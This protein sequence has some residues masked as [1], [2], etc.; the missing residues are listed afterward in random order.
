[1]EERP[2]TEKVGTGPDVKVG[3]HFAQAVGYA[4]LQVKLTPVTEGGRLKSKMKVEATRFVLTTRKKAVAGKPKGTVMESGTMAA[5]RP[6]EYA[7][8]AKALKHM[9]KT[10]TAGLR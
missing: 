2:A 8:D 7:W 9:P 6:F 3:R 10:S 4:L 5:A 1:M